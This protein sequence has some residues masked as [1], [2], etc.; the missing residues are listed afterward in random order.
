MGCLVSK[1]GKRVRHLRKARGWTL[2]ELAGRSEM[3]SSY[4]AAIERGEKNLTVE[5]VEKIASGFE[6]E[7]HQ[8]FLFS[9][10]SLK[11]EKE[12]L[13]DKVKDLIDLSDSSTKETLLSVVQAI[14]NLKNPQ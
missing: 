9:N 5:F 1:F 6:I 2:E 4:L 7:P 14:Y 8:L 3:D 13:G 11:P 10:E 12:I